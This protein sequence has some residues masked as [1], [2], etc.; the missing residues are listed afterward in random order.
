[1]PGTSPRHS[2]GGRNPPAPGALSQH[3]C[4][5]TAFPP[6]PCGKGVADSLPGPEPSSYE[7]HNYA[8]VFNTFNGRAPWGERTLHSR[9]ALRTGKALPRHVEIRPR[10]AV[11]FRPISVYSRARFGPFVYREVPSSPIAQLRN[12]TNGTEWNT[13]RGNQPAGRQPPAVVQHGSC[14]CPNAVQ[15]SDGRGRFVGAARRR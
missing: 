11:S 1:M 15:L 2:G 13:F 9:D 5:T 6:H 8:A 12:G 4:G 10:R 3:R 7:S 14:P